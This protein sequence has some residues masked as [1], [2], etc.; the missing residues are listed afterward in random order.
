MMA[1]SP[2][3]F[4]DVTKSFLSGKR[5]IQ[6]LNDLTFSLNSGQITGLLGPDGA[7]KTTLIR[8][9]T[10]LLL[11]DKGKVIVFGE[12]T[13]NNAALIQTK[14]G[15]MP[16]H[17]GLYEDLTVKENFDLY[18]DLHGLTAEEYQ[19]RQPGLLALTGLQPFI[20][21]RAAAL[22]GGMK[23]KLGL[24]C[25]LLKTPPLLLLDEPTVGV[26]PIS[27]RELWIIIQDIKKNGGTVLISTSYF[28][29]AERCD[30]V[31]FLN[32]GKLLRKDTPKALREPLIN[33]TYL[34]RE[35]SAATRR[36]LQ[37]RLHNRAQIIDAR[38]IAEGIRVLC[39]DKHYYPEQNEDWKNVA[40]SFDDVFVE[41]LGG[42]NISQEKKP[43]ISSSSIITT[44]NS[45]EE[46][47]I[48]IKNLSRKF[49]T[50]LAVKNI[51]FNVKKGEIFGLLG[52][53]GAGKTTTFRMLCG[54]LPPSSGS[55]QVAGVDMRYAP[56]TARAHI[57]YV[58]QKF[59][60]YSNLSLIQNL[61]F[62]SAV[63]GLGGK[64]RKERIDLALEEFQLS[65]YQN[66]N[67][68]TL[69]LGL[70]Q[71]LA[72]AC[73]LLHEP[74]I[75]FL[76]EPTSGVDPLARRE[77]WLRING[78]AEKGVTVLV[79][80]HFMDEAEY[81]DNL[82]LMSLGEILAQGTPQEIRA[83]ACDKLHPEPSMNDAFIYLVQHHES[84]KGNT[85]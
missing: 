80:T 16:Q 14:I 27:R 42:A 11:P 58:S 74:P 23:Q 75:L 3:Q 37:N 28:D 2:L 25:S 10:S 41:L 47:I 59:S 66:T 83:K 52:A 61:Q 55:L 60:L 32:E 67:V 21:R 20:N 5:E 18:A 30:E 68:Y 65:D 85:S 40:P 70:K 78:L 54:L 39:V 12:D 1:D 76:D 33:R 31:I 46:K 57:G 45:T 49:G 62:F 71:R 17:F 51:S 82:V 19:A 13:K 56:A 73:S 4:I 6:A 15:Y 53:N 81:C 38:I 50:F 48:D 22:S 24:G 35:K 7:G 69:P 77:F 29:E 63:Y 44:R 64:K 9:A 8:L 26:D 34:V 79:T 36:Q 84:K 43:Q 72:L